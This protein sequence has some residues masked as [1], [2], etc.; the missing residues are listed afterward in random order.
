[1]SRDKV[2]QIFRELVGDRAEK[3][4]ASHYPA[5]INARI[6]GALTEAGESSATEEIIDR[7]GIGF[8]LVDWNA[9]SAFLV[10]LILFPERFTDEEIRDGVDNFLV[11]APAHILEAARLGGYPTKNIFAEEED[12]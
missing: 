4:S 3:L 8:H 9:D 1:M 6:T 5:D 7:S 2:L 11:H 12:H 10:A